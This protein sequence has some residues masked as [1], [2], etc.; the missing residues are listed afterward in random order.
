[1]DLAV[2]VDL[3][4]PVPV[5]PADLAQ[6]RVLAVPVLEGRVAAVQVV[7]DQVAVDQVAVD[8]VVEAATEVAR[9]AVVPNGRIAS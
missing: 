9:V 4:E 7:V 1:V 8:Q 6:W 3:A 2:P 5:V